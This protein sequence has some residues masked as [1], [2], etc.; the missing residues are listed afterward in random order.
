VVVD[1]TIYAGALALEFAA[2]IALRIKEPDME[3]PYRVPW[4]WTGIILVTILPLAVIGFAVYSQVKD[5]GFV[6][7]VGWAALGLATGPPLYYFARWCKRRRGE[8]ERDINDA[9]D[10]MIAGRQP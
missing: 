8:D 6:K 2:L 7:A 10:E 1:V 9:M 4:G 5:E 3:R